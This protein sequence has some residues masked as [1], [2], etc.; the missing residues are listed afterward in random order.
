MS[1]QIVMK[2]ANQRLQANPKSAFTKD[3]DDRLPIHWAVAYNRYHVVEMLVGVKNF[4][5]DVEVCNNPYLSFYSIIDSCVL[6]GNQ[7]IRTVQIGPRL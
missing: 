3:D 1:G 2:K 5:P 4:D 6:T 7:T